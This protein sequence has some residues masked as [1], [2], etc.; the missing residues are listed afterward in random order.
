VNLFHESKLAN[1][2]PI[3]RRQPRAEDAGNAKAKKTE[4]KRRF[5]KCYFPL[6]G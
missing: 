6:S 1:R 5:A 2:D 4:D 3:C